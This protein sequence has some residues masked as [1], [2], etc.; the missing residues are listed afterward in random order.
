MAKEFKR[1]LDKAIGGKRL[2]SS[3]AR[4]A[5]DFLISGALGEA[6][7]AGFLKAVKPNH[8]GARELVGFVEGMRSKA[9]AVNLAREPTIDTCGT[10]GDG[11]QTF[12]FSTAAAF[13]VAGAGVAVAKHGNRGVSS[14]SGSADV[15]EAM[16]VAIES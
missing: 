15:L 10:G 14:R 4:E 11:L 13:I 8:L 2:G 5:M 1:L 16:G 7:I 9:V 6:E 12:N 3:G